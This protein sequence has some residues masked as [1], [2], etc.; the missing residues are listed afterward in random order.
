[1]RLPY[2]INHEVRHMLKS[3]IITIIWLSCFSAPGFLFGWNNQH[4]LGNSSRVISWNGSKPAGYL[5][6]GVLEEGSV[7]RECL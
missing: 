1:M 6:L 5:R 2:D 4:W 7:S 3:Y